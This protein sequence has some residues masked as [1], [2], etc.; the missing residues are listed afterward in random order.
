MVQKLST[1]GESG[2]AVN[3]ESPDKHIEEPRDA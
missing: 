3:A 2:D 1:N